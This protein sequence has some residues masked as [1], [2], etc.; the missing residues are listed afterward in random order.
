MQR[1]VRMFLLV[2]GLLKKGFVHGGST[3]SRRKLVAF[4]TKMVVQPERRKA[5]G[6]KESNVKSAKTQVVQCS[7]SR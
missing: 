6:N 4:Q 7:R 5:A 2:I 3:G 1:N